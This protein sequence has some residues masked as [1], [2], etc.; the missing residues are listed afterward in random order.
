MKKPVWIDSDCGFDDMAAIAMVSADLNWRILGL[1]L[2]A[3]NAS[4]PEVIAQAKR[5]KGFFGWTMP[6]HAGA[7]KPIIGPTVTADY[8]FGP[9]GMRTIGRSLPESATEIAREDAVSAMIAAIEG[10]GEPVSV[11]ALGPLTTV[12]IA[13]LARPSLKARIERIVWMG[14]AAI[15]GN[16]TATTEFNAAVDPEALSIVLESAIP[17]RM[18]GLECCRQVT[19]NAVDAMKLRGLQTERARIL[20]DLMD[21]YIRLASADGSRPMALYDPVAAAALLD[22]R[23][24]AFIPAHVSVERSGTLTRGATVCEFRPHKAAPNVEIA[25]SALTTRVIDRMMANFT[26]AAA[27]GPEHLTQ[28]EARA[29]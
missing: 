23:A 13:L 19:I 22:D 28:P 14:G 12:A 26:S 29:S 25:R 5:M 8:L 9:T 18:V 3:G 21:G 6:I 15:G 16:H 24:V 17:M 7:A 1:S 2:T 10:A 4:L 20:A 11:L 27:L